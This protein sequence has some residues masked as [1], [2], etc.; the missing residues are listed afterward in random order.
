MYLLD[1]VNRH[2]IKIKAD[3][4]NNNNETYKVTGYQL[5]RDG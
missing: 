5:I 4:W 1:R 2:T 3:E